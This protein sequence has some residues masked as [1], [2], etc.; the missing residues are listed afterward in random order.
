MSPPGPD[1]TANADATTPQAIPGLLR[2]HAAGLLTEVAAIDLLTTH[3]YWLTRSAFTAR[4]IRPVTADDGQHIGARLDW[5]QAAASLHDGEL[6]C[7][8]SEAD[9]LRIAASLGAG[10]PVVLRDVLGGLD[11]TNIAAVKA[12]ITT[13]N[14][15]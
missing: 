8:R 7:S 5:H 1:Q 9:M 6:P 15:T 3:R 2:A 12:A 13:A 14:G 11:R 4:F 10:L